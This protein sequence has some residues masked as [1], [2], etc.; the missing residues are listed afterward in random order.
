MSESHELYKKYLANKKK[1][2]KAKKRE[3]KYIDDYEKEESI[4]RYEWKEKEREEKEDFDRA[5]KLFGNIY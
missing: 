3:S 1:T 5:D 2:E 4:S